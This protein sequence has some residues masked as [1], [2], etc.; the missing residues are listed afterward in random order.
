[1][2]TAVRRIVQERAGN[3]CEYCRLTQGHEPFATFHVEHIIARQHRGGDHPSNLCLAC[4]SCNLHKGPNIA[5]IDPETGRMAP[6]FHPRRDDWH[7]HFEWRGPILVGRTAVARATI[8]V[9]RIN[10][11]ENVELR[12]ALIMEGVF[13]PD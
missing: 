2:G 1:M 10:L 3:A 11:P 6:L 13:P 4:T 9:L 5:G 8:E 12:E 7:E